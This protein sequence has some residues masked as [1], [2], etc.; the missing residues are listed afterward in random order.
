MVFADIDECAN[1]N[2]NCSDTCVNNVGSF[3]CTC[4]DGYAL[5][6]ETQCEGER[7]SVCVCV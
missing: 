2:G 6:D 4:P 7:E 5:E 3:K 1:D